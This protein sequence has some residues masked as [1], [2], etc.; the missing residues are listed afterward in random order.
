MYSRPAD[1]TK[2]DKLNMYLQQNQFMNDKQSK[3]SLDI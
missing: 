1:A 3:V 2:Y